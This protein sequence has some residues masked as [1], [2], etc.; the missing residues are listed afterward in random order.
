M[1]IRLTLFQ[2]GDPVLLNPAQIITARR[3]E[4]EYQH[5]GKQYTNIFMVGPERVF[6][7]ETLDEIEDLLQRR[8]GA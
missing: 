1:I 7:N 3:T 8:E 5:K 4:G 2:S 6:V